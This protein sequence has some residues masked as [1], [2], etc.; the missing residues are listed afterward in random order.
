MRKRIIA[1]DPDIYKKCKDCG[2]Y[3][4]PD[5]L[6]HMHICR[7]TCKWCRQP[8][9]PVYSTQLIC[10]D[11]RRLDHKLIVEI[12][13]E[14][15]YCGKPFRSTVM[16]QIYCSKECREQ[17]GTKQRSY[18]LIYERDNFKCVYCGRTSFEDGIKLALDHIHPKRK[19]GADTANNIVTSC[20]ECNAAKYDSVLPNEAEILAEITR[21]NDA[22]GI[23]PS[24]IIKF[25]K[26]PYE[27]IKE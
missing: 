18:L 25:S 21:R 9:S 16:G 4:K 12:R 11:C 8:F 22:L 1:F 20:S 2:N 23:N 26:R 24:T 17:A 6:W 10:E 7:R 5:P 15:K 14:C 3:Y 27:C 13:T 19:G